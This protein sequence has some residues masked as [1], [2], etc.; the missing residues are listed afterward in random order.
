MDQESLRDL[1][2]KVNHIL[3]A[4]E[5]ITAVRAN[6]TED[7]AYFISR[8]RREL[9]EHDMRITEIQGGVCG[10]QNTPWYRLAWSKVKAIPVL[11]YYRVAQLHM[12]SC[13]RSTEIT[14]PPRRISRKE[15]CTLLLALS[16]LFY[17]SLGDII[18]FYN[19][20]P[21][22]PDVTT[23]AAITTANITNVIPVTNT[24]HVAD[25]VHPKQM[26]SIVAIAFLLLVTTLSLLSLVLK[27]VTLFPWS[28]YYSFWLAIYLFK[29]T[30]R[31]EQ[32]EG[33]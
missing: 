16:L 3:R 25:M 21:G 5:R 1:R 9:G 26:S 33:Q 7:D 23:T 32:T 29:N 20:F 15:F 4:A 6:L 28:M 24:S 13:T 11:T 10:L 14:Q 18:A 19:F 27:F 12:S 31:P 22:C 2:T 8:L 17:S 30:P